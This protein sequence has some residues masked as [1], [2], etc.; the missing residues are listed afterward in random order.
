MGNCAISAMNVKI[1]IKFYVGF[2]NPIK[3]MIRILDIADCIKNR[4]NQMKVVI[5]A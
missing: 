2:A 3:N 1:S 5:K 4:L